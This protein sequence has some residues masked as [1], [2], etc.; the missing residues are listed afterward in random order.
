M[1]MHP[2]RKIRFVQFTGGERQHRGCRFNLRGAQAIAIQRKKQTGCQESRALVAVDKRMVLRK[3]K[4]IG[5]GKRCCAGGAVGLN[6]LWTGEGG[7]QQALIAYSGA[8]AVFGEGF[9]VQQQQG[10]FVDPA[11]VHFANW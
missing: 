11:P 2:S 1:R 10:A 3:S 5:G 9:S 6:V 7:I 4:S 8:A